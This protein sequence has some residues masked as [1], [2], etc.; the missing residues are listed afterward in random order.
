MD[1]FWN[2]G[3]GETIGGVDLLGLR[4][5]DQDLES[6]WVA[7][8]TT[9]SIRA[10]YLSLLVWVF[11]EY[12]ERQLA[13]GY[14][15][16]VFD[17]SAFKAIVGR[18]EFITLAATM[19]SPTPD[20]SGALGKRNLSPQIDLLRS[21]KSVA[22]DMEALTLH[23]TY[24][25]PCRAVGLLQ[26]A[27]SAQR[28]IQVPPAGQALHQARSNAARGARLVD[29]VFTGGSLHR[30]DFVAEGHLFDLNALGADASAGERASLTAAFRRSPHF[31]ETMVWI[32]RSVAV[33]RSPWELV[34]EN[35]DAS[36]TA[37][38]PRGR[39]E[40]AFGE[41]ELRRR[42]HFALEVLLSAV[43][44]TLSAL[45]VADLPTIF[46][47]WENVRL[48][49]PDSSLLQVVGC[50]AWS[51]AEPLATFVAHA[52]PGSFDKAWIEPRTC[53]E[54]TPGQQALYA[55]A[56]LIAC[57]R[58]SRGLRAAGLIPDRRGAM[59]QVFARLD[60]GA[61]RP[62]REVLDALVREQVVGRHLEVT[63]GKMGRGLGCSLRFYP[64]GS[65]LRP[66]GADVYGGL[67]ALRLPNVFTMLADL[68]L[69]RQ[70]DHSKYAL[71]DAG[72][73]VLAELQA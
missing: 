53:W 46:R 73:Q 32:F 35:Y 13:S 7:G 12:Y 29:R 66:L 56:L 52:G 14:G 31:R 62:L 3:E 65:S 38:S 58:Q 47:Q 18:L 55:L 27:P 6:A 37:A 44:R 5:V 57:E 36:T 63:L 16:S 54:V 15:S 17:W 67:S 60:E 2:A 30:D 51:F 9:V 25:G 8:V 49:E 69:L 48:S 22:L 19:L 34:K 24:L 1:L 40:L 50:D 59:E 21:G 26:D 23:G 41:L 43:K 42:V 61:G 20:T 4:Q 39:I 33:P 71:T 64:E 28:P 45:E 68:G 10:R 70:G 72:K 11:A